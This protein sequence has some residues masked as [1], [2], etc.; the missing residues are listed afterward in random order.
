MAS[1]R[2]PKKRWPAPKGRLTPSGSGPSKISGSERPEFSRRAA[3]LPPP[4]SG[5]KTVNKLDLST[6]EIGEKR[7]VLA[8]RDPSEA[9]GSSRGREFQRERI[10]RFLRLKAGPLALELS[11]EQ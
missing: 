3:W 8:H 10:C 1:K 9:L 4:Q 6:R 5:S 7:R 2:S 11:T